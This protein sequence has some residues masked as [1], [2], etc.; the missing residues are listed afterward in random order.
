MPEWNFI[1]AC[2]HD[3][4]RVYLHSVSYNAVKG[5]LIKIWYSMFL[6]KYIVNNILDT[7]TRVLESPPLNIYHGVKGFGI[8]SSI[9]ASSVVCIIYRYRETNEIVNEQSM[10]EKQYGR[11]LLLN[12][13][14]ED[15][16]SSYKEYSTIVL[17][18]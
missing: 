15:S 1:F 9:F 13:R 14:F 6:F 4:T 8:F 5:L 12:N 16:E 18:T 7:Q 2:I 10:I 3:R 17:K 11:D